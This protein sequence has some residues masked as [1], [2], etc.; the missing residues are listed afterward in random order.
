MSFAAGWNE[1]RVKLLPRTAV[2]VTLQLSIEPHIP[3]GLLCTV[4]IRGVQRKHNCD[5]TD[6]V[7]L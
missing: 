5:L 3:S 4:L 6:F 7:L 2:P 1:S